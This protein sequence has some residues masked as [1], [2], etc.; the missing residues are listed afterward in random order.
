MPLS[1]QYCSFFRYPPVPYFPLWYYYQLSSPSSSPLLLAIQLLQYYHLLAQKYHTQFLLSV[2]IPSLFL[3]L[4]L[5]HP[6]RSSFLFRKNPLWGPTVY[7][8][9]YNHH[10]NPTIARTI[11]FPQSRTLSNH[12][13]LLLPQLL[14]C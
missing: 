3:R 6:S 11:Q 4:F 5:R 1:T 2:F 12:H 14:T 7:T 10:K 8:T 13:P 9:P